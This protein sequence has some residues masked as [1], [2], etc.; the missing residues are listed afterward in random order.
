MPQTP[1]THRSPSFSRSRN[2]PFV[3]GLVNRKSHA[4]GA[5]EVPMNT[6]AHFFF[7]KTARPRYRPTSTGTTTKRT[8]T[9]QISGGSGWPDCTT[10]VTTYR[11]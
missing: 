4:R 8:G 6:E 10:P 3:P 5:R 1:T 7:W 2:H 11:R 9:N